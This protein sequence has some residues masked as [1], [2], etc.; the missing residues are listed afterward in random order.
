M[1]CEFLARK[2][3][4]A[5]ATSAAWQTEIGLR[6]LAR[7]YGLIEDLAPAF[8]DFT[9]QGARCLLRLVAEL[10]TSAFVFRVLAF[11][12]NAVYF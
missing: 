11:A 3:W 6:R 9:G 2:Y 7:L 1:D 5:S 8:F 10:E 4:E 12:L